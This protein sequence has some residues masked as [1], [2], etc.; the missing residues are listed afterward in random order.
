[1][2]R[3]G[4][5]IQSPN[6]RL[7]AQVL[8]LLAIA[9]APAGIIAVVQAVRGY[10]A[11]VRELEAGLAQTARLAANEHENIINGARDILR[12]LGTQLDVLGATRGCG[13]TLARA[14]EGLPQY[15]SAVRLDSAGQ[16]VCA[17]REEAVGADLS[18]LAW[19]RDLATGRDFVLSDLLTSRVAP[20]TRGIVAARRLIGEAG[21]TAGAV[22]VLVDLGSLAPRD[23]DTRLPA[24]SV[25]GLLDSAGNMLSRR[26]VAFPPLA[27]LPTFDHP[28]TQLQRASFRTTGADGVSRLYVLEP[29]LEERLFVLL[30]VPT[31]A[32]LDPLTWRAAQLVLLTAGVL[33]F[34]LER[35]VIRWLRY[36]ERITSLYAAGRRSVRP[37]RIIAAP[38]EMRSLGETFARMADLID[39]H[40]R[41]L[42]ESVAQKD[43][44]VREVHHRVKNNL[45]LVMS[46]LSLH[47]RRVRDP[48]AELAFTEVRERITALATLHRRLYESETLESVD[49]KWFI[50]DL[51]AELRKGGYASARSVRL[52]VDLPSMELAADA[53]VPLGLLVT[54]AVSNAFKHAFTGRQH[55][56]VRLTARSE[57]G[58]LVMSIVDDGFGLAGQQ[59]S[60]LKPGLGRSL[61][62]SFARQLGGQIDVV[63]TAEGTTVTLRF[64]LE[65][66]R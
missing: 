48:R 56:L 23:V 5:A 62:E 36:L 59:V 10:E 66:R 22:A 52:E 1:M 9:L 19:F 28:Q 4:D 15:A 57:D 29:L 2:S 25:F 47:G 35:L 26:D 63:S 43:M 18:D 27:D 7:R 54:E 42:R 14:I 51:C 38:A 40:E 61:M 8:I 3:A 13:Q 50:E 11:Q 21:Q 60:E 39:A 46:L 55:G 65:R 31:A 34:G 16:V 45:Q 58:Q 49:L 37:E 30:G 41:E 17:W 20:G 44:L 6:M 64:P 24:R 53:A 12:N 32:A 33:W